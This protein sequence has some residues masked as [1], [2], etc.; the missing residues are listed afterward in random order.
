MRS[1]DDERAR[2]SR[3][4]RVLSR[5]RTQG[6][7]RVVQVLVP[8]DDASARSAVLDMAVALAQTGRRVAVDTDD[9]AFGSRVVRVADRLGLSELLTVGSAG[10]GTH[11]VL[12]LVPV[13]VRRPFVPPAQAGSATLLTVTMGTRTSAELA[14]IA[15][16]AVE[17]G[18]PI[19]GVVVVAAGAPGPSA[20]PGANSVMAGA[21]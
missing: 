4:R 10:P 6:D 19:H 9:A 5:I 12:G 21:R 8:R 13:D 7:R 3:Y 20:R 17:S 2:A 15:L 1:V 14:E 16:A 18:R 11:T